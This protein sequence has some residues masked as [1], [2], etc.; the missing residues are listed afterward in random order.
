MGRSADV[1]ENNERQRWAGL[2]C[3]GERNHSGCAC[4]A[5]DH[6]TLHETQW[7]SRGR[8]VGVMQVNIFIKVAKGVPRPVRKKGMPPIPV[9]DKEAHR[10][11]WCKPGAHLYIKEYSIHRH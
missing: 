7:V 2:L 8:T 10:L 4:A 5:A 3:S 1:E 6:H 9:E 11:W